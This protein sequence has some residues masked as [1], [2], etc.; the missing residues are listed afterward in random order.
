MEVG[1]SGVAQV[2]E[3]LVVSQEPGS[4]PY[5][6]PGVPDNRATVHVHSTGMQLSITCLQNTSFFFFATKPSHHQGAKDIPRY[7]LLVL[8]GFI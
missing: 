2:G 7:H 4:R 1:G 5:Y 8:F 3:R 6:G